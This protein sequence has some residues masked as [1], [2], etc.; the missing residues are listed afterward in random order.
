M[1]GSN[2]TD[3]SKLGKAK[4]HILTDKN[5]IPSSIIIKSASTRDIKAVIDII[6][7]AVLN[8][9]FESSF[10]KKKKRNLHYHLCLD[11]EHIVLNQ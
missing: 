3:R 5:G 2:P 8:R 9:T 6:A 7:N 10:T 1:T 11:R 4:R